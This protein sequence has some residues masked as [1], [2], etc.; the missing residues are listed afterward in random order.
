M[1][2]IANDFVTLAVDRHGR[3]VSLYNKATR[4]EL[5]EFPAAAGG[6]RMIVPSGRHT[7]DFVQ[8]ADQEPP[9]IAVRTT[10]SGQE[11][12]IS[13]AQLRGERTYAVRAEFVLAV[14]R[15]TSALTAHVELENH[16]QSP[17]DEVEFPIIGGLGGF[18][19]RGDKR[20]LDMVATCEDRGA[21]HKDVLSRGLP[22]TGRESHHYVRRLETAMFA[23]S[24]H[25][26]SG[27]WGGNA[28]LWVDLYDSRQGLYLGVHPEGE[29]RVALKLEKSPKEVPNSPHAYPPGTERWLR[30]AALHLPRLA[31]GESWRSEPVVL[32]PHL[33]DWHV[34]ANCYAAWRRRDLEFCQP[35]SWMD[36]FV[37]WTEILGKTYLGEV[38]HT[39][40]QC[41]D[42]VVR[43]HDAT[44]ID[45]VFYYGHSKIGAEGA[46]FD[47]SPA[48]DLGD[49][50][51]FA[52]MLAKLHRHGIRVVLLDHL[53]RWIN[54]DLPE[55]KRL[56]LERWAVL[57]ADGKPQT[58]R[59][60]KETGLSCLDLDGPT[61]EW[62]EMCPSCP[63]W[64]KHYLR[65]L[66]KMVELGVD[67][68]EL[69]TFGP[70]PCHHPDHA[71]EPGDTFELK[72][73]FIAEARAHVKAL[74]PDFLLLGETMRPEARQVVDGFYPNRYFDDNGRVFR[75]LFPEIRQQAVL[76]GNYA[77]DQVNKALQLGLG[78]ETEIDGLRRTTLAACPE[79]AAYIG[80]VSRFKRRYRPILMHGAFRDTVGA[81]VRGEVVYSV[82]DGGEHG[83]ALVLRNPSGLSRKVRARFA[84]MED[85]RRLVVWRPGRP[86]RK[87]RGPTLAAAMQPY[88]A[89][90]L[91]ALPS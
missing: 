54:R 50:Q 24:P 57:D 64:R 48:P 49:E 74:N 82:I 25:S 10:D 58:A 34:G 29:Q 37:G 42:A 67:G 55:Y 14:D 22:V 71:H 51:A 30:A 20:A 76:V 28:G 38:F 85:A 60:W 33:G 36:D 46:D 65:H 78:V 16:G 90:V 88:E 3:V 31:P 12:V 43:D 87:L 32:M 6:W 84:N 1:K 23:S 52:R 9:K 80:E 17:I 45:L 26:L 19:Q 8:S 66:T 81:F 77:Y 35:P 63:A 7:I 41:A 56:R 15:E 18:H 53:H 40:E 21:F 11:L 44:G 73:D 91:L 62:V 68:L 89:M 4:T 13:Y 86:E 72:L 61:P 75:Y 70:S 2:S 79:L 83:R 27:R 59:W 39:Y 47:H 69:D 5:I